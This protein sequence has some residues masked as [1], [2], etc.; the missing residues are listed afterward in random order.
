[1]F[2]TYL[3][4]VILSRLNWVRSTLCLSVWMAGN[5]D[6]FQS[7]LLNWFKFSITQDQNG[8]HRTTSSSPASTYSLNSTAAILFIQAWANF[9]TFTQGIC[10]FECFPQIWVIIQNKTIFFYQNFD[11]FLDNFSSI[12]NVA[13]NSYKLQLKF[14]E[15]FQSTS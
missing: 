7:E 3:L 2:G 14:R 15:F 12:E 9:W 8:L 13:I 4:Q 11:N 10:L 1:M 6:N 5:Y